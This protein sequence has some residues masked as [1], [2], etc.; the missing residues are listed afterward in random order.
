MNITIDVAT[1]SDYLRNHG[2]APIVHY[3]LKPSNV[4]LDDDMTA[5]VGDFRLAR[6]L[7][8][9]DSTSSLLTGSTV[10]LRG[11]IGYI[12]PEYGMGGQASI[13]GD[14]YR[15]GIL[16]LEMFTGISPTDER[17]RNGLNLHKHV[18]MAF[19][20]RVTK[21]IDHRLFLVNDGGENANA[22]V[23]DDCLGSVI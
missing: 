5:H 10:G 11:S 23:I 8:Q 12:P 22:E 4:L 13:E 6:F 17:F 7:V 1:A 18:E 16:V 14:A 3:D 19:S 15:Y 21:I 9:S 20:D 2:P